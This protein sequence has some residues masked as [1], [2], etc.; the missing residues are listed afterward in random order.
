VTN[1]L[2]PSMISRQSFLQTWRIE[3]KSEV[4]RGTVRFFDRRENK[5]FGIILF[6]HGN[7]AFFHFNDG[8]IVEIRKE[9]AHFSC[10][11]LWIDPGVGDGVIFKCVAN[12][13][14]KYSCPFRAVYWAFEPNYHLA[15]TSARRPLV[16]D[17][18]RRIGFLPP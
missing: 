3:M 11:K 8:S 14:P 12:T 17:M 2:K 18:L 1:G 13:N 5:R 16:T 7:E 9:G 10:V 4:R 6:D 15:M